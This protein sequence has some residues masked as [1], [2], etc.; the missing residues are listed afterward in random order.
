[1]CEPEIIYFYFDIII[2]LFPDSIILFFIFFCGEQ[3][4]VTRRRLACCW[5]IHMEKRIENG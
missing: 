5:D 2:P 1:M 3:E 4:L